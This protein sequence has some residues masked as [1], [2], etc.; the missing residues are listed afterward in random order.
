M[1]LPHDLPLATLQFY[2]TAPYPCS[3]L[4]DLVARSQVAAPGFMIDTAVY[5]ELV[6]RG[7]R[8]SGIFTYRPRCDTCHACVPVRVPVEHFTPNRSQRRALR[9]HYGMEVS[10]HGLEDKPEYFA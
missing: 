10:L 1:T 4:P 9:S 6:Q 7:F 2:L 3:Y 5:S 8:R